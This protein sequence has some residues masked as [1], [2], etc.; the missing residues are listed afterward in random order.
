MG[1]WPQ[2]YTQFTLI[3]PN[4]LLPKL[5]YQ[6][7]PKI[8]ELNII[9]PDPSLEITPTYYDIGSSTYYEYIFICQL[10]RIAITLI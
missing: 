1:V 10:L 8:T 5:R 9:F 7:L 4:N 6:F 2:F 3:E